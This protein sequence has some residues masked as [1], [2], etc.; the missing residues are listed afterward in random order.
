MEQLSLES[1][2]PR[3]IGGM[4]LLGG[5]SRP[6]IPQL[7]PQMFTTA[8]QLLDMTDSKPFSLLNHNFILNILLL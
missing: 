6:Q 7:P 4:Q 2:S 8:A 1:D 5:H 3:G